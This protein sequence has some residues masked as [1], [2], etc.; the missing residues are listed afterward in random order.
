MKSRVNL[1][2]DDVLYR[3]LLSFLELQ[4]LQ[5]DLLQLATPSVRGT[6]AL[7]TL[8]SG[9]G[10]VGSVRWT[11]FVPFVVLVQ[12]IAFLRLVYRFLAGVG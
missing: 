2:L 8:G 9:T 10:F 6:V 11:V 1:S 7:A 3:I 5:V 12:V 4:A